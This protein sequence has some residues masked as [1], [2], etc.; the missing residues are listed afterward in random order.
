[1]TDPC[2]LTATEA[3]NLIGDKRLSPVELLDSCIVR[4]E[5]VNP[6]VNAIC[7]TC[8]DRARDE[9]KAAEEAV[10]NGDLLGPLH[11]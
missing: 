3:R 8:F 9:A 1:M 10:Q 4:I 6:A 5:A 7:G 11:G 2:D